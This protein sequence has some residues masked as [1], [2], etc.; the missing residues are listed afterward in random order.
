MSA[1]G[2]RVRFDAACALLCLLTI[3]ALAPVGTRVAAAD[4]STP[5]ATPQSSVE[6]EAGAGTPP[7]GLPPPLLL[8]LRL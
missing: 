2:M 4:E 6:P 3:G 5:G 8:P 1:P 7:E